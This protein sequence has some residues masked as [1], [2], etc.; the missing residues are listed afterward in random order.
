MAQRRSAAAQP[1]T[2]G[3]AGWT[4]FGHLPYWIVL[5]GLAVALATMRQGP[6]HVRGGTFVLAGVLIIAAMTRLILPDDQAGMLASRRRMWDVAAFVLLGIGLL[7]AGLV[8]HAP[9]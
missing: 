5:A 3:R 9:G 7:V 2:A 1:K 8:L 6:R 4:R